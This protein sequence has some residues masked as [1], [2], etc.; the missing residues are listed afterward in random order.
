MMMRG[1]A[2][3]MGYGPAHVRSRVGYNSNVI[4]VVLASILGVMLLMMAMLY[5]R[6]MDMF[7]TVS[8]GTVMHCTRQTIVRASST[9]RLSLTVV[10]MA[11]AFGFTML[12]CFGEWYHRVGVGDH[13][14]GAR[15]GAARNQQYTY[16]YYTH[17]RQRG[18]PSTMIR[19]YRGLML[20]V[21][22][23]VSVLTLVNSGSTPQQY[24]RSSRSVHVE[25]PLVVF[26]LIS[27]FL[28]VLLLLIR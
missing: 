4:W 6:T 25:Y 18:L 20:L 14:Y 19:D 16:L 5:K 24:S 15:S 21:L 11:V 1:P 28:S 9:S 7:Y 22:V 13:R 12:Q 23:G 8:T 3:P 27:G 10:V 2:A 26:L 17:Q